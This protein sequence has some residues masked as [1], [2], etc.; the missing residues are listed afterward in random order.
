VVFRGSIGRTDLP[1]GDPDVME[2]T[3]RTLRQVVDPGAWL[4]PGHG[5][6]TT[7]AHELATNPYLARRRSR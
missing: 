4:L 1:G 7:M 5:P 2:W 6:A 3:L